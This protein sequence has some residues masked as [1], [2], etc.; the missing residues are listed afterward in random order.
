MLGK[1]IRVLT[2]AYFEEGIY[3]KTFDAKELASGV[4]IYELKSD[5]A[6]LRQKMVLQK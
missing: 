5:D 6:L 4:Y 1:A 2:D 3:E